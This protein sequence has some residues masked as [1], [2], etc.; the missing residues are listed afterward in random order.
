MEVLIKHSL[1]RESL[2]GK[3]V[4]PV[5]S[6]SNRNGNT[7]DKGTVCTIVDMVKGK[8]IT[9]QTPKCSECGQS[10]LIKGIKRE[11][12]ELYDASKH[13]NIHIA[14]DVRQIL[15]GVKEVLDSYSHHQFG[16][17]RLAGTDY[18]S[19]DIWSR[20]GISGHTLTEEEYNE[21]DLKL[22]MF[23]QY[24]KICDMLDGYSNQS[25]DEES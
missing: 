15:Q 20:E 22:R 10:V 18:P 25:Y 5:H 4:V 24:M 11:E 13:G 1:S 21:Y 16:L 6:I 7:V 23:T 9:I 8:G 19:I 3:K 2:I 14:N 17:K 12:L